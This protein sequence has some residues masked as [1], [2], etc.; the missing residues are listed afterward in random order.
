MTQEAEKKVPEAETMPPIPMRGPWIIQ[1][2]AWVVRG[3]GKS[4]SI[5]SL[6]V[7]LGLGVSYYYDTDYDNYLQDRVVS[8]EKRV[9]E[10]EV[11]AV[12]AGWDAHVQMPPAPPVHHL[13]LPFAPAEH[14]ATPSADTH[15]VAPEPAPVPEPEVETVIEPLEISAPPTDGG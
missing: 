5:V 14:A 6:L 7:L 4:P 13:A 12:K 3:T 1:M 9:M 2:L 11:Q 8:L 15:T 10:L